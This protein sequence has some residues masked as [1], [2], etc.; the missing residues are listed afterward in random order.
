MSE[1]KKTNPVVSQIEKESGNGSV[2]G[3]QMKAAIAARHRETDETVG[4]GFVDLVIEDDKVVL[5]GKPIERKWYDPPP[6]KEDWRRQWE[7]IKKKLAAR[8]SIKNVN[9]HSGQRDLFKKMVDR[10]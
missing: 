10:G 5:C 6:S 3:A 7:F 1:E 9:Q 4:E 8:G 2:P